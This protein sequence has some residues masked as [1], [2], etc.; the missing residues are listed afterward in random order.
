MFL[1]YRRPSVPNSFCISSTTVHSH[2]QR[3]EYRAWGGT[4]RSLLPCPLTDRVCRRDVQV[5]GKRLR[6]WQLER[7]CLPG[8][9]LQQ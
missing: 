7:R 9:K 8:R 3:K 1:G 2:D 5:E 4:Y 6:A